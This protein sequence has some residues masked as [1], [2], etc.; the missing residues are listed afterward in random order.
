MASS[1]KSFSIVTTTSSSKH[2]L[3]Y[4]YSF[5]IPVFG[6][7]TAEAEDWANCLA[8]SGF[9]IWESLSLS[10]RNFRYVSLT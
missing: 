6:V 7:G 10:S 9:L 3:N 8:E 4:S 2:I 1:S 5:S